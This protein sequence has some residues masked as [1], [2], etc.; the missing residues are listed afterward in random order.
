MAL[1]YKIVTSK[2]LRDRLGVDDIILVPQQNRLQWYGHVLRKEDKHWVKKFM[3]YG[4]EVDQRK[5]GREIVQ[6]DCQARKLNKE[7]AMDRKRWR[8]QIRDYL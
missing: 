4:Q 5:L 6:K 3:E 2:G 7:D 8:K 1:S